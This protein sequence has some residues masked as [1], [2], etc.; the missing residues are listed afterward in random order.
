[1]SELRLFSTDSKPFGVPFS[2][3]C[4]R[5]IKWCLETPTPINPAYDNTGKL[6]NSNQPTDAPVFFLAGHFM[7]NTQP[8]VRECEVPAGRHLFFPVIEKECSFSEDVDLR[9]EPE[10]QARTQDHVSRITHLECSVDGEY[11]ENLYAHKL[12]L[13][14]F[15]L[16]FPE[17]NVYGHKGGHTTRSTSCGFWIFLKDPLEKL[18]PRIQ[19]HT[20]HFK[21]INEYPFFYLDMMYR[22]KIS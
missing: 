5:W 19:T 12:Q 18:N 1:L 8:I 2:D 10:L 9:T 17:D 14:V 4:V 20:V 6:A 3:W 13:P 15:D 7:R 21:G 22:I 11:V 16:N